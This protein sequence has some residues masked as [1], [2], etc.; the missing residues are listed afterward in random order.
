MFVC[1]WKF[2]LKQYIDMKWIGIICLMLV[3]LSDG[4]AQK[5]Q[6]PPKL[7]SEERA[8]MTQ[9]QRLVYETNR[10]AGKDNKVSKKQKVR[11]QK[12]QARKSKRIKPPKRK[13]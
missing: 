8:K 9:E 12:Q 11:I 4:F 13:N 6:K 3:G 7:S 5:R 1:L 10:K 2:D